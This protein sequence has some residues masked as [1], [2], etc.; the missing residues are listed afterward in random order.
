MSSWAGI[1]TT[2]ESATS[3]LHKNVKKAVNLQEIGKPNKC[4]YFSLQRS[5][6]ATC[7]HETL[8]SGAWSCHSL[9]GLKVLDSDIDKRNMN[10][11]IHKSFKHPSAF[12]EAATTWLW[13]WTGDS[14]QDSR[15]NARRINKLDTF[16]HVI[17][18][19]EDFGFFL[20]SCT[21]EI[22][23]HYHAE[24]VRGSLCGMSTSLGG[25]K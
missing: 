11:D 7:N 18:A 16:H 21:A 5:L 1:I 19:P 24:E 13:I 9:R 2:T 10:G 14:R 20:E 12:L 4:Y 3:L 6:T 23:F 22:H 8:Q 15:L 17:Q 25:Y